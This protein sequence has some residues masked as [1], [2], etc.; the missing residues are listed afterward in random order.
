[1]V[2]HC[3]Q[4]SWKSATVLKVCN[5]LESLQLSW[6]SQTVLTVCYHLKR[7]WSVSY[8]YLL[9]TRSTKKSFNEWLFFQASR[10]W[11]FAGVWPCHDISPQLYCNELFCQALHCTAMNCSVKHFTALQYSVT[12][13]SI[14]Y[15]SLQSGVCSVLYVWLLS[16]D[17]NLVV[18]GRVFCGLALGDV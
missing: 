17:R 18:A 14:Y 4:L 6:Q 2:C 7:P 5:C 15:D 13:C 12:E 10:N 11:L 1:M 3:P 8:T 16:V 9:C